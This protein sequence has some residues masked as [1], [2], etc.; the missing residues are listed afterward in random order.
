MA[1]KKFVWCG[2]LFLVIV[3]LLAGNCSAIDFNDAKEKVTNFAKEKLDIMQKVFGLKKAGEND[4]I[5]GKS[6]ESFGAWDFEYLGIGFFAGLILWVYYLIK[7]VI[8]WWYKEVFGESSGS[9]NNVLSSYGSRWLGLVAN[10]PY[11]PVL[12]GVGYWVVMNIPFLNRVVQVIT[13][14]LF[15]KGAF[16]RI[17]ALAVIFGLLPELAEMYWRTKIDVRYEKAKTKVA[18][19]YAGVR[20][21]K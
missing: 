6:I 15:L 16:S 2:F 3:L 4:K 9:D 5:F 8:K 17:V 1:Y 11:K 14:D 19:V 7:R 12:I 13:L 21:E 10:K 20:E 18:K